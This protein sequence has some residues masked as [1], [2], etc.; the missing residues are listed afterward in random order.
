[1]HNKNRKR[2]PPF[3]KTIRQHPQLADLN[4]IFVAIGRDAWGWAK[5][6]QNPTLV[7]PDGEN[8]CSYDWPVTGFPVVVVRTSEVEPDIERQLASQL[9][10]LGATSVIAPS[11]YGPFT[12]F[13]PEVRHG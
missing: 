1:M 12:Y 5:S 2:L 9:F 7:L 13:E 6:Q 8:P 3:G 4:I 11:I 10:R